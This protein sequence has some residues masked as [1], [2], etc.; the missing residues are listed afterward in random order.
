MHSE[1][2]GMHTT[3]WISFLSLAGVMIAGCG[4]NGNT[5]STTTSNTGSS[6]TGGGGDGG[7][8]TGGSG[9][10]SG[11][12]C[13]VET[14]MEAGVVALDSGLVRGT[15][16]SSSWVYRG[17]P[18]AT[19]PIGDKRWKPPELAAC[20]DGVKDANSFGAVCPQLDKTKQPIG[21]E[22]CLTL[23]VWRPD[24]ATAGEGPFPVLFF[25]HGGGN[26]QGSSSEP[27]AGTA[28]VYNGLYPSEANKSIVVTIN[29]RL[30]PLGFLTLPELSQESAWGASGNYGLLDQLAALE[31]VQKNIG[32]F[33]GDPSKVMVFGESAGAVD[34]ITLVASPL[35]KGLFSSALAQS[36]GATSTPL[37]DAEMA[38]AD[39]V[40]TTSCASASDRL[41]CLRGKTASELVTE[42]PGNVNIGGTSVGNA[43]GNYGPVIDGHVLPKATS[44]IFTAGEHNHMPFALGTNAEELAGLLAIKVNTEA[45][46]TQV[47]NLNFGPLA[48]DV[49]AAYAVT[50]Y[51]SPQ[52]ALVAV[53][54]DMR[55]NC[56]NRILAVS[57][58]KTQTEPVYRYFFSRRAPT[59]QGEKPAQHAIE[60]L[61][62]FHTLTD[63][64]L[65]NPAQADL[66]L[67]DAMMGY[68]GRFGATGDPN[69]AGAIVW[70]KYDPAKDTY[71]RFDSPIASGE[72]VRTAQCDAW[73]QILTK[74]P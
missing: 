14:S 63:I 19:P 70:P 8:G 51:A 45:E 50:D 24:P 64:P 1:D 4:D 3:R 31:W 41:G 23:N 20:W 36:G 68:W 9:G 52:D 60:L 7:G 73:E 21:N 22:D 33:G 28:P 29:Y 48:P 34:T 57:I 54:S 40:A 13:S 62:V 69:G 12:R 11:A 56:P 39:R 55:F 43:A 18:Y 10:S 53:Y 44:L 72:G 65:Y 67:S 2:Q 16:E 15:K 59:P 58:A 25:I 26:V 35:S 46:F 66:D 37:K 30:G 74:V 42:L 61:Y 5:T 6:S 17:I 38:T 27:V 32:A 49:L 47:I 71:V